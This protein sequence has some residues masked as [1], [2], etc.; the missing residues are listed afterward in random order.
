MTLGMPSGDIGANFFLC[1]A[2]DHRPDY[3]TGILGRSDLQAFDGADSPVQELIMDR[4]QEDDPGAGGAFLPL[5]SHCG[6]H[7][8]LDGQ[9]QIG[10]IIHDNRV[11][12]AHL[13]N[14]PLD[15]F[16]PGRGFP[17][18]LHDLQSH[19]LGAGKGNE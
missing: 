10:G 8:A 4:L 11:L 12:A 15:L 5:I 3:I 6:G 18:P 19:P 2:I 7:H 13:G 14:D 1:G 17:R 9:V 16:L